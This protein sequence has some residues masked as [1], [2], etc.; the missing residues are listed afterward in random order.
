MKIIVCVKQV[1]DPE[2]PPDSFRIDAMGN[3][4]V[5]VDDVEQVISTFDE[6]A[7]EAAL[8]IKDNQEA[9]ITVLSCG[10]RLDPKVIKK[11]LAMGCDDLI[12]LEGEVFED[13]DSWSTAY[14]LACAI[15]KIDDYQIILCGRQASDWDSGQVGSGVA[16]FLDIPCITLA[17]KVEVADNKV[18]VERLGADGIE[19][20]EAAM[21]CLITV[22]SEIGEPR[23]ASMSG[24]MAAA[25]KEP[26]VWGIED[27]GV[28]PPEVGAKGRKTRVKKVFKPA[29]ETKCEIIEGE[30]EQDAAEALALRLREDNLL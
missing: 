10:G 24:I 13:G 14:A 30:T 22:S 6:N 7:V 15:R 27:I 21:P 19:I 9:H 2:A 28:T 25:K 18:K 12:L 3:K 26:V 17:K 16:E 23:Y 1:P 8:N 20:V 4:V 11:P 5:V 29:K